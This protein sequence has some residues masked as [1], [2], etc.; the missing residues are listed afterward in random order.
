MEDVFFSVYINGCCKDWKLFNWKMSWRQIG[1]GFLL[2]GCGVSQLDIQG[3][4]DLL[5]KQE[6]PKIEVKKEKSFKVYDAVSSNSSVSEQNDEKDTKKE[7]SEVD[8]KAKVDDKNDEMISYSTKISVSLKQD[9]NG[10]LI[11]RNSYYPPP[12]VGGNNYQPHNV[13]QLPQHNVHPL[14][15]HVQQVQP[16]QPPAAEYYPPI[17]ENLTPPINAH[18]THAQTPSQSQQYYVPGGLQ[19]GLGPGYGYNYP[20]YNQ[21]QPGAYPSQIQDPNIYTS[22]LQDPSLYAS[23]IQDPSLYASQIQDPSLYPSQIQDQR[24]QPGVPYQ[25]SYQNSQYYP[26]YR[27]GLPYGELHPN[28]YLTPNEYLAPKEYLTPPVVDYD[29][30][31][32]KEVADQQSSTAKTEDGEPVAEKRGIGI[33]GI[34]HPLVG[35][36]GNPLL[37]AKLGGLGHP[38]VGA[39]FGGLGPYGRLGAYGG[40][41]P[42]IGPR[43]IGGLIRP[44]LGYPGRHVPLPVPVHVPLVRTIHTKH[45]NQHDHVHKHKN[46]HSHKHNHNNEHKHKHD[47]EHNHVHRHTHHHDHHHNHKHRNEH[48]HDEHHKHGHKH[49]HGHEHGHNHGHQHI[50]GYITS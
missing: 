38:L 18:N 35:A 7:V 20:E 49:Q 13:N 23:Q 29:N 48:Q 42:P 41:R 46:T 36:P 14:Q 31:D 16:V 40:F 28:E 27:S 19:Y 45:F 6:K 30:L 3:H 24:L 4:K 5:Q 39:K 2:V 22:Q 15:Q 9:D 11:D 1:L 34:G 10:E 17:S 44:G 26:E 33:G 25:P 12:V 21:Q 8:S 47:E 32:T 50:D 37:G 43:P